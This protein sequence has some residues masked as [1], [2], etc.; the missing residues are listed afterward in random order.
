VSGVDS[1]SEQGG[2]IVDHGD[3][4][5][6]YTP[7]S[8]YVGS[9]T[10][11]YLISDGRGGQ[12]QGVV[13]ITVEQ[14][15]PPANRDPI[16][17][18]D[19]VETEVDTAVTISDVLANDSDPDGDTLSIIAVDSTSARGGSIEDHGDGSFTYVPPA[20]F[21]G[22]DRFHYTVSD[23]KGGEAEGTVVITV[24]EQDDGSGIW[25]GAV[26]PWF[27]SLMLIPLA[28]GW[29]RQGHDDGSRLTIE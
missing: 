5:F 4:T 27:L 12:A 2:T 26:D 19:S 9:D 23:G 10:F 14:V 3:G 29:K 28:L 15:S 17:G 1:Q 18:D 7:P 20:G 21:V 8:G 25:L 24:N 6:T 11:G 16:A 22:E 13:R